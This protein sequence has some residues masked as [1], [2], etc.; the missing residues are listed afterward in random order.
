VKGGWIG[1]PIRTAVTVG[2][3]GSLVVSGLS[4]QSSLS[5]NPLILRGFPRCGLNDKYA[6]NHILLT[7]VS[8]VY[9]IQIMYLSALLGILP[10]RVT[11]GLPHLGKEGA[12]VP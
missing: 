7:I 11:V 3:R 5:S 10:E 6:E 9:C 4:S 2:A 8:C 12:Y 1:G